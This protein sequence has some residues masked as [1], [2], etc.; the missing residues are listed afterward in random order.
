[1]AW[2]PICVDMI[3]KFHEFSIKAARQTEREVLNRASS[4]SADSKPG[5][6]IPAA[7]LAIWPGHL[8]VASVLIGIDVPFLDY[9]LT[10][11]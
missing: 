10:N 4:S 8:F 11:S 3:V 2:P 9:G 1:M 7:A 6:L 5:L